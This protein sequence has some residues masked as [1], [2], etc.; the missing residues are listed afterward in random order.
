MH[1]KAG[2]SHYG[3]FYAPYLGHERPKPRKLIKHLKNAD[4][5][6]FNNT[7]NKVCP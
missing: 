6:I 5:S 1:S 2:F 7:Q 4:N 3:G